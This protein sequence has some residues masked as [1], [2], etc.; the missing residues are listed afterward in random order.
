VT[1]FECGRKSNYLVP[2]KASRLV[3]NRKYKRVIVVDELKL[4][5]ADPG[6]A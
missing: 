6:S 2:G 5:Y 3:V 4:K 1:G